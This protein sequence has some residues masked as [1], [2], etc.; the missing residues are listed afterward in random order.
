M[1]SKVQKMKRILFIFCLLFVTV[2]DGQDQQKSSEKLCFKEIFQNQVTAKH[3]HLGWIRDQYIY[4]VP[5]GYYYTG[6]TPEPDD[7]LE[8]LDSYNSGLDNPGITAQAQASIVSHGTPFQYK[9]GRWWCTAFFNANMSPV[10]DTEIQNKNLGDNV[11]TINEK[12]TTTVPLQCDFLAEATFIS[13]QKIQGIE[14][15]GTTRPRLF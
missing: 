13:R 15:P 2:T 9:Q 3:L 12:C 5:D 6:N 11:Q 10:D 7:S 14:T 1:V 4:S 8:K